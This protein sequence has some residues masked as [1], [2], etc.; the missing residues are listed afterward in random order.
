MF[1]SLLLE[2]ES[3]NL[4][5]ENNETKEAA[6]AVLNNIRIPRFIVYVTANISCF[7]ILFWPSNR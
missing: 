5:R 6:R 2:V 7:F 1:V 3:F 4:F